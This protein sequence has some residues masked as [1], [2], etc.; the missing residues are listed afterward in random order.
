[1]PPFFGAPLA[2]AFFGSSS[3]AGANLSKYRY[4]PFLSKTSSSNLR[5]SSPVRVIVI[6]SWLPDV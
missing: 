3:S 6:G 1:V 4:A 5:S 2:A